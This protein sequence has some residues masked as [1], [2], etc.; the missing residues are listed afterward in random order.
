MA[1]VFW[2]GNRDIS[3]ALIDIS[4]IIHEMQNIDRATLDVIP[5]AHDQIEGDWRT[6]YEC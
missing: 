1:F 4:H 3:E 6:P 2:S 5:S